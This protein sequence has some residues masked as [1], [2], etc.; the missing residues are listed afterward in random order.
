MSS[1]HDDPAAIGPACDGCPFNAA[2]YLAGNDD[3]ELRLCECCAQA[4]DEVDGWT[5]V[6]ITVRQV[7]D[8]AIVA[9]LAAGL[10]PRPATAVMVA[11]LADARR[12]VAAHRLRSQSIDAWLANEIR[13]RGIRENAAVLAALETPGQAQVADSYRHRHPDRAA[14]L[15][16]LLT[17]LP[18]AEGRQ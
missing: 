18:N 17:T 2:A 15:G 3:L 16:A 6:P 7:D 9:F 12:E 14:A 13:L 1:P 5:V 8:Q 11:A 4:H 10:D